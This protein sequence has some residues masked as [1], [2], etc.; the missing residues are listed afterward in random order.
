MKKFAR[1]CDICGK[2]FNIGYCIDGGNAYYCS[3]PCLHKDYSLTEVEDLDI[4]EDDSESYWTS[5]SKENY[6]YN[7]DGSLIT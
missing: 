5:W 6:D 7:E 2:L 3:I 1:K 4:G